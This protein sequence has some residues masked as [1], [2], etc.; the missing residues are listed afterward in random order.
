MWGTLRTALVVLQMHHLN[1]LLGI[2]GARELVA[3]N[4]RYINK[5]E[6][7][8]DLVKSQF[9]SHFRFCRFATLFPEAAVDESDEQIISII[10]RDLIGLIEPACLESPEPPFL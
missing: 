1:P 9:K 4:R 3:N 10:S 8:L 2:Y 5:D 7:N 6:L